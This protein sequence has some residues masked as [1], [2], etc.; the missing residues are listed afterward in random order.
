MASYHL[1]GIDNAT[2]TKDRTRFAINLRT[3]NGPL[4]LMINA[5]H[6]DALITYLQGLEYNASLMDPSKGAQHGEL[7]Q[8]RAEIVDSH[9]IG[10]GDINGVPSVFLG[11][12]SAQV[13]RLFAL[14]RERATAVQQALADQIPK[15]EDTAGPH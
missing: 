10:R 15:L 8:V 5:E 13:F 1:T 14:D 11:L 9:Q 12:K 4:Q 6:L 7:G 2:I 3:K